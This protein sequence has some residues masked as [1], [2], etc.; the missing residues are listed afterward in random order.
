MEKDNL[1]PLGK[2]I[3]GNKV[4]LALYAKINGKYYEI[5]YSGY[6]RKAIESG[7]EGWILSEDKHSIKSRNEIT[8][9]DIPIGISN[10]NID[11]IGFCAT[12][13]RKTS[14]GFWIAM[15][16]ATLPAISLPDAICTPSFDPESLIIL[17]EEIIYSD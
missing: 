3:Y 5:N 9:A 2:I 6:R 13:S 4:Y 15:L 12:G 11:A 8:F 10:I 7:A 14:K 16:T 1:E 17:E